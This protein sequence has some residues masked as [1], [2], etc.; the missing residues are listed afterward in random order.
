MT[1]TGL[2]C[3]RYWKYSGP[4]RRASAKPIHQALIVTGAAPDERAPTRL[5]QRNGTDRAP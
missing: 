1:W 3:Q 5:A 2:P 4:P